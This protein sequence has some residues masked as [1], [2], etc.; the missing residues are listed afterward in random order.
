MIR[1]NIE[2]ENEDPDDP[3]GGGQTKGLLDPDAQE[4][5][6]GDTPGY[7]ISLYHWTTD[8]SIGESIAFELK[9]L[10]HDVRSLL[11]HEPVDPDADIVFTFAPYGRWMHI[12]RQLSRMPSERRPFLIHWNTEGLPPPNLPLLI[13]SNLSR[14]RSRFDESLLALKKTAH[15][16]LV[17][18]LDGFFRYRMLRYRYVG[19]YLRTQRLGI[20]FLLVDISALHTQR[21]ERMGVP[22]INV[23]YGSSSRWHADLNLDRDIDVLWIGSHGSWRRTRELNRIEKALADRN[24]RFHIVDGRAAPFV[25][26]EERTTL[27]NRSKIVLNLMR[28]SYDDN[29]LRHFIAM[30]NRALVVSESMLKHNLQLKPGVHYVEAPLAEIP[31]VIRFY[32][33]HDDLRAELVENACRETTQ[34][35]TMHHSVRKIICAASKRIRSGRIPGTA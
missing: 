30:P 12:P 19:D 17:D 21:F 10:G 15:G 28:T 23:P 11:I 6:S 22:C 9:Q 7:R 35:L 1:Q 31:D 16:P 2:I 32:L 14:M 26:G 27:I 5:R 25:H 24:I 13:Q 8:G 3:S 20:P 29:T 33:D 4:A 34:E 18:S